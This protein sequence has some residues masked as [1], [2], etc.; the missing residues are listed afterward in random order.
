MLEL[1]RS[2]RRAIVWFVEASLLATL[3]LFVAGLS[4]GWESAVDETHFV[5]A[6]LISAVA[7]AS[8]YYHGLY[9]AELLGPRALVVG[10]VRALAVAGVVLWGVFALF[11][12][13]QPVSV[14]AGIMTLAAAS[15]VLPA[16]RAA[17]QRVATSETFSKGAIVLGSGELAHACA[18]LIRQDPSLGLRMVGMLVRDD[19]PIQGRSVVGR[20]RDL[21]R[22]VESE[23]I[24][25][26]VVAYADRR[27]SFPANEL[28]ELKFRG[29]DIEEGVDFYERVANK[30]YVRELKPSHLIFA[31]GFQVRRASLVAKRI[32]DVVCAVFGLLLAWPLML[33][34][35][36]A[37]K[38][39]SPGPVFY[40]QVR[41]GAYGKEFKIY[42]FRSM[43]IDAEKFGAVFATEN[44]PRVTRVGQFIRK[45][46]LDELPQ[47]WNV[48]KGDMSMVGPRPER[49]VFIEKLEQQIPFFR[50]RL[51]V[52]PG[53]TG[54]A[55][56]RA[57]YASQ[58]EDHLEKLSYDLFY[59]KRFSLWFDVSI[60]IDTVKVVLLRIGAR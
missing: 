57:R 10:T 44:D 9:G 14:E 21:K 45:T 48:L 2:P 7:Q 36:L 56:V 55:Q 1:F 8:L 19:E 5:R 59:I 26:V 32:F 37:V 4:V 51:F 16:W 42:K 31:N 18:D 60:L 52:K 46:R 43:R 25:L 6:F 13:E 3:V 17:Y 49:P 38:L 28:L 15:I 39:D 58:D 22:L 34:T 47:L 20:C 24:G 29:V 50:Q 35:A 33:L 30:L 23:K 54:H 40:S 41:A 27:G 53:V 11:S 12:S